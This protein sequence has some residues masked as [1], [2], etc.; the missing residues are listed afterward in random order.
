M[1][2]ITGKK[3]LRSVARTGMVAPVSPLLAW[4][5]LGTGFV[6]A[7]AAVL[8]MAGSVPEG[9]HVTGAIRLP[10]PVT[11]AI[12]ALFGL[13]LVVFLGDL[14]RRAL[15]KRNRED[16][17][18]PVE[19]PTPV[20]PWLRRVTLLL[21][22][23]NVAVL[24]Y[25]WRRAVLEGGLFVG[26]GGLASGLGLPDME[27]LTAPALLNWVFGSLAVMAGL[28]ALGLALWS[29]LGDR[30]APDRED[31]DPAMPGA[32]LQTAVEESLDDLRAEGDPRRAIVRCYARFE[33]VAADS[34]LERRPWLTPTEFMREVLARLSL[35]RAAVPTLTGLFE[36]ARF[37]HHPLGPSERDR[38]VDAL[39]EIRSATATSEGDAGAG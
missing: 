30:L 26:T 1:P 21:S 20:P 36:L 16:D 2:D 39:H 24:A 23:V 29:A 25:L 31:A 6:I 15:S 37:S 18:A 14:V 33:R 22:L 11:A 17:G 10:G 19:E 3:T 32:P 4:A 7:L 5:G 38:A 12:L 28:G 27:A 13:A 35:P 34:G 8:R 9:D